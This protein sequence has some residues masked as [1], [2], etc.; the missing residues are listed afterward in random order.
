[1]STRLL[2]K[3]NVI[4]L[5]DNILDLIHLIDSL[6]L[7]EKIF[8]TYYTSVAK[9]EVPILKN[10]SETATPLFFYLLDGIIN[11]NT[12]ELIKSVKTD[13]DLLI[14]LTV[15]LNV[16]IENNID[17]LENNYEDISFKDV[18][19]SFNYIYTDLSNIYSQNENLTFLDIKER[20]FYNNELAISKGYHLFKNK[21][22]SLKLI[23]LGFDLS[24]DGSNED[25]DEEEDNKDDTKN[26]FSDLE[27]NELDDILSQIV[28]KEQLGNRETDP[29]NLES[30]KDTSSDDDF[31]EEVYDKIAKLEVENEMLNKKIDGLIN[32]M[33]ELET[34]TINNKSSNIN[35]KNINL[36]YTSLVVD[37]DL[38]KELAVNL[39]S[40]NIG[41][42]DDIK[43]YTIISMYMKLAADK[44]F[45]NFNK[46]AL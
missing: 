30:L 3:F 44:N 21:D 2:K 23:N 28:L 32:I 20:W 1:M 15:Q 36:F 39:A 24:Y 42:G 11:N 13:N 17:I 14:K 8:D 26:E 10:P 7:H 45:A 37:K 6:N 40:L 25:S 18:Y 38:T 22:K 5:K 41:D 19:D 43:I 31:E 4:E 46:N 29:L 12:S 33:S 27:N 16:F 9:K 34:K 35:S